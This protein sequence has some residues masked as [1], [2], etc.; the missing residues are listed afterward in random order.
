MIYRLRFDR[1]NYLVGDISLREI[2][3]KMGDYFALKAPLWIDIWNPVDIQFRDDSDKKNVV[4]PPDITCWFTN[5]LILNKKAYDALGEKL[6]SCG[7]LLPAFCEGIPYWVLHV[8]KK[9]G[10]E[11]VNIDASKRIVE[12]GGFIDM[13]TL[14]FEEGVI[15]D[16]LIFKTEFSGY[17]NIYCTEKFKALIESLGLKGLL[18]STDLACVKE[19]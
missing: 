4:T 14:E 11:A 19:P 2:K 1:F 12:E 9:T 18:F 15:K 10:M 7:E 6:S 8:T 3:A 16:L 17:R 5:E 13:Q